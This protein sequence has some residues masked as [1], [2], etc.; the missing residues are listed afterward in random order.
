[1]KQQRNK[2]AAALALACVLT[3][4]VAQAATQAITASVTVGTACN[5]NTPTAGTIG[6]NAARTIAGSEQTGGGRIAFTAT[7]TG[8]AN[9]SLTKP[10]MTLG[11]T[12]VTLDGTETSSIYTA[13]TGAAA[14]TTASTTPYAL[15]ATT[16]L[17]AGF[18]AQL[19]S[20][21]VFNGSA[22]STV[23]AANVTASCF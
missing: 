4:G 11:G 3:S 17:Y 14:W 8:T 20:S 12:A 2:V 15:S 16:T 9:V 22:T 7:V 18:Q 13:S 21:G 5:L 6:F 19:P 23:Y 10:T 1:M